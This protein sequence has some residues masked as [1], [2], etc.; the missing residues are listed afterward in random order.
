MRCA[1]DLALRCAARGE[2]SKSL[3]FAALLGS[4]RQRTA[5]RCRAC[6]SLQHILIKTKKISIANA[7]EQHNLQGETTSTVET[8]R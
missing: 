4:V 5:A 6:W 3:R 7:N 1:V 2:S 8:A